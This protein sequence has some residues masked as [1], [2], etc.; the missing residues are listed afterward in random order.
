MKLFNLQACYS[1]FRDPCLFKILRN[2]P[3]KCVF[4][5]V[6]SLLTGKTT[7]DIVSNHLNLGYPLTIPQSKKNLQTW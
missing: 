1:F 5:I 7:F 3:E 4:K 6:T 2:V